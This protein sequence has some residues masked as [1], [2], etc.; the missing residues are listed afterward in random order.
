MAAGETWRKGIQAVV[1]EVRRR[2]GRAEVFAGARGP[3]AHHLVIHTPTG[4]WLARLKTKSSGTWQD[5]T[6]NG[7]RASADDA[8]DRVWIYVDVHGEPAFYVAPAW[9]A[10]NDIHDAHAAY[11]ARHGGRRART[12]D[13]THHAIR[14]ERVA[15]WRDRWDIVGL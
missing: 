13:T 6:D 15:Q 7:A 9:W 11:L 12:P 4:K 10:V 2:G 8:D 14:P 1:D 5:N 3:G